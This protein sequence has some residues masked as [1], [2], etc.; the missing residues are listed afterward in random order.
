MRAG[1]PAGRWSARFGA[2]ELRRFRPIDTR[3]LYRIRN[4]RSV[5]AHMSDRRPLS[6]R[7]HRHWVLANLVRRR[8]LD[9][10]MVVRAGMPIGIGLLRNFRG[11]TAEFGLMF[12]DTERHGVT[13]FHSAV[14][15]L[16]HAFRDLRLSRLTGYIVRG[17]ARSLHFGRGLGARTVKSDRPGHVK[18]EFTPPACYAAPAVARRLFRRRGGHAPAMSEVAGVTGAVPSLRGRPGRP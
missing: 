1:K 9:L 10:Y 2:T 14:L 4:D 5:R 7:R 6:Y 13:A 16:D 15:I 3:A 17:N 12:R 8:T 18:V 11:P